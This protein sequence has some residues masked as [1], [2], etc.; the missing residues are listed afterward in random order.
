MPPTGRWHPTRPI[1][2]TASADLAIR[3]WN[4]ADGTRLEELNGPTSP[5]SVLSFN[6]SGTRLATAARDGVARSW[7][8]R[9]LAQNSAP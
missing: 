8:P 1:L 2:V 9:S 5:P 6:A 3:L 7:E 4:L